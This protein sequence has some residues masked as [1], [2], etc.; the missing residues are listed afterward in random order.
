[1]V[2]I[3]GY[4]GYFINEDGDIFSNRFPANAKNKKLML[5]AKSLK[6]NGYYQIDLWNNGK[7]KTVSIH[8]L[9]AMTYLPDFRENLQVNHID[10]NTTN[11]RL[12]N[13]EMVTAS[14][15]IVHALKLGL[16]Y[17]HKG[18]SVSNS[19]LTKIQVD[20]IRENKNKLT[21]RKLASAFKVSYQQISRII[22]N[23]QWAT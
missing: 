19:K 12:D 13:L 2:P 7:A 8:R 17:T 6:G 16:R 21:Q 10:G 5:R 1:M 23:Q 9:L 4:E 3:Q 11:N 20:E 18:E 22:N 14:Q 15:N